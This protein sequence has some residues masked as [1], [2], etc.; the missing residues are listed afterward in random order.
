MCHVGLH[1]L[2]FLSI[3]CPLTRVHSCELDIVSRQRSLCS[4]NTYI[5]LGS[6]MIL[7]SWKEDSYYNYTTLASKLGGIQLAT[8]SVCSS[9][10]TSSSFHIEFNELYWSIFKLRATTNSHFNV[11]A[12]GRRQCYVEPWW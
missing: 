9:L 3:N 11:I 1:G 10:F 7:V 6:C 8:N 12:R 4:T 5:G 2:C